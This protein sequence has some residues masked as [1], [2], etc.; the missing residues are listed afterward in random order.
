MTR[1]TAA[2][3]FSFIV[4]L[5]L[6]AQAVRWSPNELDVVQE[7]GT[8]ETY[9]L[10]LMNET[11]EPT[12]V[13]VFVSDWLRDENGHND[14]SVPRNG[15]RWI[16]ERAFSAG[17]TVEIRYTVGLPERGTVDVTGTYR[18]WSPQVAGAIAGDTGFF[19]NGSSDGSV[20][21]SGRVSVTREIVIGEDR[22]AANVLLIIRAA[23]D[24]AGLTI[25]ETF[26]QGVDVMS[27][28]AAGGRFDTINRSSADWVDVSHDVVS[29]EPNESR[30]VELTV[31]TPASFAGTHWCILHAESQETQV[32]GA[33]AGTQIVSRP[34]VGLKVMVT[35]PGTEILRGE[36]L[37]VSVIET[38]RLVLKAR[39]ANTGNVQL[40]VTAEAEV[41]DQNGASVVRLSFSEF[42]RDYF[43][44]LP[45][46]TRTIE[47]ADFEDAD[48]LPPGIYQAIV[49]FDFGGESVVVGVKGFRVR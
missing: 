24:F 7:P 27:L 40:V 43:R 34:S 30:E 36:V 2:L 1:R 18:T 35:A 29:L 21:P 19:P 38:A 41:V 23:T 11:D 39:F 4:C 47:I 45:G 14:L 10:L 6:A 46:S 12:Q 5:G 9:T 33:I 37:S 8:V 17:E 48:S 15:A 16:L 26:S 3:T 32:I 31:R 25:E 20:V 42:G 28:D 49:S 13:N 22:K 44:I